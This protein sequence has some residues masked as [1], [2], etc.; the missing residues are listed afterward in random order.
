M[1]IFLPAFQL[2][3]SYVDFQ[4]P[5]LKIWAYTVLSLQKR[6]FSG[7]LCFNGFRFQATDS[8]SIA[9][10]ASLVQTREMNARPKLVGI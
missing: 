4:L 3:Y 9:D 8:L 5:I 7:S 1:H 6:I 10:S 2:W